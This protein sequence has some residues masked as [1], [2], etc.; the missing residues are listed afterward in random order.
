MELLA[1]SAVFYDKKVD[2]SLASVK[3]VM[4][5]M[6]GE[7][8]QK[9]GEICDHENSLEEQNQFKEAC[10]DFHNSHVD[11]HTIDSEQL[12][13]NKDEEL[14]TSASNWPEHDEALALWVK[15][16]GKWQA[17]I[18][19][20]RADWPLATVKAKPT[21][22]RKNYIVIFFP[23]SRNYSWAD[24]LLVCAIDELPQPIAHR[25]HKA[26]MQLVEDLSVARRFILKKLAIG[27]LN[28]VDLLPSQVLSETARNVVVWREFA[29]EASRC[30]GYP[31]LGRL[32]LKLQNMLL[33]EYI[34]S[35]WLQHSFPL[36]KEKCQSALSADSIELLKEE[37]VECI[38]WSKV[39]C[40]RDVE[41]QPALGSEWKMWKHE[42]MKGFSTTASV[43][44]GGDTEQPG[45][46]MME[47]LNGDTSLILSPQVSRKRPKLEVRRAEAN[48]SQLENKSPQ[49]I[50][51][52][53]IDSSFFTDMHVV[54]SDNVVVPPKIELISQGTPDFNLGNRVNRWDEDVTE[55][56][57]AH[58][59]SN[60]D[61]NMEDVIVN[62]V[63]EAKSFVSKF[64]SQQCSA[65]IEAK[66]RRCVRWANDGDEYCCVHLLSRVPSNSASV[67]TTPPSNT[68]ICQGTTTTGQKCKHRSVLGSSF[69]KKHCLDGDGMTSPTLPRVHLKRKHDDLSNISELNSC[70]EIVIVREAEQLQDTN[71]L[72]LIAENKVNG[73]TIETSCCVGLGLDDG[74]TICPDSPNR[75]SL[76]C[77]KHLPIWLKRARNGKSRII[78]K[79]VFV[80]L[81]RTCA[82]Q[83]QKIHLHQACEIFYKLFKSILSTRNQVPKEIH[84][85]WA[86]SEV[87]KDLQV[88]Q[89]LMKL[90]SRE[91]ERLHRIWGVELFNN[92]RVSSANV[93]E[94][95]LVPV[96][97]DANNDGSSKCKICSVEFCDDQALG[98]HW[99]DSHNKEAQWLFR[100]YACAICLDSFTNKKV[101]EAH[102]Q[103]RHHAQFVEHCM[104]IQCILCGSHY[105]N[106][107]ELWSHVLSVHTERFRQSET[108]AL[109]SEQKP[110]FMKPPSIENNETHNSDRRFI[111]KFCGLKF[112]LLPDLGRHH[113]AAH[114]GPG[115][116]NSRPKKK[117]LRF[118]TYRLQSGRLSRPRLKKGISGTS[119]RLRNPGGMMLKKRL[120]SA[121]S[122][123][124]GRINMQSRVVDASSLVR[125]TEAQCSAIAK[126]LCSEA[127]KTKARPSNNEILSTARS[128]CCKV[129]LHRSLEQKYGALPERLYLKAAK[130]CS[131]HNI[132]VNW[133]QEGFNCS[134]GCEPQDD[135]NQIPSL[136]CSR[137][138]CGRL[139]SSSSIFKTDECE[140]D[141]CHYVID[142]RHFKNKHFQTTIILCDDISFG[143]EK[144]P[145]PCVVE[146]HL[147][148]SLHIPEYS[149][150][151][152]VVFLPW[153]GF[154]YVTKPLL[155]LSRDVNT[156]SLQLGCSCSLS[157]CSPE[158]C[159][160]VYLF[161]SDYENA[162]DINGESMERRF[163]YDDKGRL[164]LKDDYLVY[165]CNNSCKCDKSCPNRVVQNGLRANLEIFRTVKKGWAVRASGKIL[166]GTFVCELIGEVLSLVE[167]NRRRERYRKES[168]DYIFDTG[169]HMKNM[170][171]LL[172][173]QS[174]YVIDATRYG[175]ISRFI[176][177]S[178]SPNLE[179]HMVLVES[180]DFQL[181][182]IGLY[183]KQDIEAG[184]E[185][186]YDYGYNLQPE[187]GHPCL[188]EA[189]NCRGRVR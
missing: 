2:P 79:E 174:E 122:L 180:M 170:S 26:G 103:E 34:D 88:A 178:C 125:L 144:V 48:S 47:F 162:K 127:H 158:T 165:E 140:M 13:D 153:E 9:A 54:T 157:A 176:N 159:D 150:D 156:Q 64:R 67:D 114:M 50:P 33:L 74:R 84:L 108:G 126:I 116:L 60:K 86:L 46:N 69:C 135:Q 44:G 173:E 23:H 1:C 146:R 139:Y 115:T 83:M 106:S 172:G 134:R 132:Q 18:K 22:G 63:V 58:A 41:G 164:I 10:L 76:Y 189:A 109:A 62:G 25:S 120:Q 30:K 57:N 75:H 20:E 133:H 35:N 154:T 73:K 71:S 101:L 65:F 141:E 148:D 61:A 149:F 161:N 3:A 121:N 147:I 36:W 128:A 96:V 31:D 29:A 81:L 181:A 124:G 17:G 188:C 143:Q 66:G 28:I 49:K 104:L 52:V 151:G 27:V 175:N 90:V 98:A 166:R 185:L 68:P 92:D 97:E 21:H 87:C 182:H 12:G 80:D 15:W 59:V 5:P 160:H 119:Y 78:S 99:I 117:G 55:T 93:D 11:V 4:E 167:A 7:N 32:L 142:S 131:E 155:D 168:C 42:A 179:A 186:S 100:G 39:S 45:K 107:E 118:Y 163:P 110:I 111:C 91:K 24:T 14:S 130:L 40:F 85:Q 53:E 8:S 137:N 136:T 70:K 138:E 102:V 187:E 94:Q 171:M 6:Q 37:F 152:K 113:Q 145:V 77:E 16:R 51:P 43:S 105:G 82:S 95:A 129:G 177:H 183:A 112:D 72:A 184:E 38:L 56:L 169:A 19:C 123:G 89:L